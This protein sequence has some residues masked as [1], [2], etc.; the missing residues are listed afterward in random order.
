MFSDEI[1]RPTTVYL[2]P[3][4]TAL[5]IISS[6]GYEMIHETLRTVGPINRDSDSAGHLLARPVPLP[7]YTKLDPLS[8]SQSLCRVCSEFL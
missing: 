8:W 3:D 4:Y 2:E 6:F 5:S 1:Y 7:V